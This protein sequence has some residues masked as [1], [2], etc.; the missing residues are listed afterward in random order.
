MIVRW[1]CR[2][3]SSNNMIERTEFVSCPL[4]GKRR[5]TE[6]MTAVDPRKVCI[7]PAILSS[8]AGSM[9]EKRR[10]VKSPIIARKVLEEMISA[11]KNLTFQERIDDNTVRWCMLATNPTD[12]DFERV[13]FRAEFRD[14]NTGII[15]DKGV[16]S[17]EKWIHGT[18]HKLCITVY[19]PR[20][21]KAVTVALFADSLEYWPMNN[22]D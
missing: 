18:T 1:V 11:A 22:G 2:E 20:S 8:T 6:I 7:D 3:C 16:F 14:K 17:T 9:Y 10:I 4:C 13:T 21:V 19:M 15:L 5:T 12:T